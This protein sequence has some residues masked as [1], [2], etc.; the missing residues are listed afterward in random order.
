MRGYPHIRS[1]MA[2]HTGSALVGNLGAPERLNYTCIGTAAVREYGRRR[3]TATRRSDTTASGGYGPAEIVPVS[4]AAVG[5][6]LQATM[7]TWRPAC[8]A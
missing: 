2:L 7:S 6:A 5:W 4:V 3:K 1:R 8:K